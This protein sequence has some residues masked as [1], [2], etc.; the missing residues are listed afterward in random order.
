MT[1]E[2][3]LTDEEKRAVLENDR[4]V[5]EQ[6]STTYKDFASAFSNEAV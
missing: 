6:G 3:E 2:I 1:P 5:R 4:K